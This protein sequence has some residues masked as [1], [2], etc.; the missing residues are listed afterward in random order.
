[1]LIFFSK[2]KFLFYVIRFFKSFN[3]KYKIRVVSDEDTLEDLYRFRY[4]I[5]CEVDKLLNKE[6]Y[7]SKM[8]KDKYDNVSI[9]LAAFNKNNKVVAT[10]RV[11]KNSD[12][13][14][15]TIKEFD[16][17]DNLEGIALD[18]V[19]EVSRFMI[20]PSFRKTMLFV[21]LLSAVNNV[22]KKNNIKFL[23]GCVEEWFLPNLK[24]LV[25][26]NF[27]KI[28]KPQFCFNAINYPFIYKINKE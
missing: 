27:K 24:F 26:D 20:D 7:P 5:Y 6:D 23:I 13:G 28:D 14:L 16:L 4:K 11:I 8:E 1:M 3:K 21:D 19:A 18:E 12:K 2:K 15:P 10:T 22:A 9:H 25:Q 17:A